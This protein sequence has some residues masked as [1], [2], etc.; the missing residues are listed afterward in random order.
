MKPEL[1]YK[2]LSSPVLSILEK[3]TEVMLNNG[4]QKMAPLSWDE[5]SECYLSEMIKVIEHQEETRQYTEDDFKRRYNGLSERLRDFLEIN[6]IE[7]GVRNGMLYSRF[8]DEMTD[9]INPLEVLNHLKNSQHVPL[10]LK[11]EDIL[12]E[13]EGLI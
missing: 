2:I 1:Q 12:L 3:E 5:H 13:L 7:L 8:G 9:G 4:W 6:D 11:D 10:N